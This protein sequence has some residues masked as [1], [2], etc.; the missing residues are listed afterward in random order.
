[1]CPI[2]AVWRPAESTKLGTMAAGKKTPLIQ[3]ISGRLT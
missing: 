3:Q 2:G 1:M